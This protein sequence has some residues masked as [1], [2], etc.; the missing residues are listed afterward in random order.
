MNLKMYKQIKSI[1][2]N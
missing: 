2:C 1:I